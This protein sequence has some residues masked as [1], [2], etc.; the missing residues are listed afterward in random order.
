MTPS[1]PAAVAAALL[2]LTA[3]L[4]AGQVRPVQPVQPV[5]P[6]ATPVAP[7][8]PVSTP[9]PS[10][11]PQRPAATQPVARPVQPSWGQQPARPA[12]APT[13]APTTP[14]P[15]PAAVPATP[16]PAPAP[17]AA[18][19]APS[20][21]WSRSSYPAKK[22]DT[23]QELVDA[24]RFDLVSNRRFDS[25]KDYAACLELQK[26]TGLC[27]LLYFANLNDVSQKGLCHWWEKKL[28]N[29]REWQRAAKNYLWV[30]ITLPGNAEDRAL[31]EKMRV[32]TTPAVF[33][34][35]PNDNWPK[36]VNVISWSDQKE[37]QP[38]TPAEGLQMLHDASTPAYQALLAP[39]MR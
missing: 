35:Q 6:V 17:D 37:P 16:P 1:R 29:S 2:A 23:P 31:A 22:G 33:V 11:A 27:I 36:R 9:A 3:T 34:V 38:A 28:Q 25:A 20:N 5:R 14:E 7:V 19:P 24:P 12:P 10:W 21:A 39:L 18:A 30:T 8:R 15:D 13:S 32:K 4:A 26:Q